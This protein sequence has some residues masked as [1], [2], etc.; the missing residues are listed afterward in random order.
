LSAFADAIKDRKDL[1]NNILTTEL[2]E[3]LQHGRMGS[4][5]LKK[6]QTLAQKIRGYINARAT[7]N[8]Q[9][10]DNFYYPEEERQVLKDQ[11]AQ[12]YKTRFLDLLDAL[13]W[14]VERVDERISELL[15][16][17]VRKYEFSDVIALH[18]TT[19]IEA[20]DLDEEMGTATKENPKEK[21]LVQ[22]YM[23]KIYPVIVDGSPSGSSTKGSDSDTSNSPPASLGAT[24]TR[25]TEEREERSAIWLGLMFRM[26]S[27]LFLHDFNPED[28]MI[29][30]SEFKN[31]RLPVYIG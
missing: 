20:S 8:E 2:D 27:W 4:L 11:A 23:K 21:I 26:W 14:T 10:S 30:R 31:N 12:M 3:V 19:V 22:Y 9:I 16:D 28:K 6:G 18:L 17:P 1:G 24:K 15:T 5:F 13:H 7:H 29:E 25:F